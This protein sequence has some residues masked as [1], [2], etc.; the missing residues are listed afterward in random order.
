VQDTSNQQQAT[1]NKPHLIENPPFTEIVWPVIHEHRSEQRK[2]IMLAI[3]PVS[4]SLLMIYIFSHF[5]SVSGVRK[6]VIGE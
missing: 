1:R 3:S 5:F 4:P 6:A 2:T